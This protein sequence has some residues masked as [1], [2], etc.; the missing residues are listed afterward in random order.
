MK[1][2]YVIAALL[3]SSALSVP[4]MGAIKVRELSYETS[5]AMVTLPTAVNGELA[6]QTCATCRALRLRASDETRYQ[7]N[8]RSVTLAEMKQFIARHN[9]NNMVVMQRKGTNELSRI[10]ISAPELAQ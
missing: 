9:P 4:S 7:I 2:L 1:S 8:R 3:L 6:L 5:P 10:V